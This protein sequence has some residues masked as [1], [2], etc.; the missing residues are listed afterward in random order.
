MLVCISIQL[1]DGQKFAGNI[2]AE[3]MKEAQKLI[4]SAKIKAC[5]IIQMNF[6]KEDNQR[7][8]N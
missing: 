7:K 5:G 1:P 2:E 6:E 4:K 3:S 8:R